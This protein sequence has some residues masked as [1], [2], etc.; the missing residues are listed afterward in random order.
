MKAAS[1]VRLLTAVG[2][3]VPGPGADGARP[4]ARCRRCLREPS[5]GR[6][7][8]RRPEV[9]PHRHRDAFSSPAAALRPGTRLSA[10]HHQFVAMKAV[11]GE[12]AV[13]PA[14]GHERALAPG[15][16]HHDLGRGADGSGGAWDRSTALRRSWPTRDG[17]AIDQ[18]TGLVNTLRTDS[19][20]AAHAGLSLE[21]LRPGLDGPGTLSR[22]LPVLRGRWSSEP[23]D[24]PRSAADL[25]L[26]VPFNIALLRAAHPHARPAG[27]PGAR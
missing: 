13:V 8:Q 27:G 6:P 19:G 4:P 10:H 1:A 14:R 5:G 15:T 3:P 25:F 7:D 26:G 22:L 23:A 9:G 11:K 20:L 17:G 18:V 12:P 24:L 2:H 21:R 16:G